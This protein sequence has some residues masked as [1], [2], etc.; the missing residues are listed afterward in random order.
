MFGI[1]PSRISVIF[2]NRK[3][4]INLFISKSKQ[5]NYILP[6]ALNDLLDPFQDLGIPANITLDDD[7][8]RCHERVSDAHRFA[9]PSSDPVWT[10]A[11]AIA[12]I[13]GIL[14]FFC[15]IVDVYLTQKESQRE[16]YDSRFGCKFLT[17]N[18]LC[19]P[20]LSYIKTLKYWID[21]FITSWKQMIEIL[22]VYPLFFVETWFFGITIIFSKT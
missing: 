13:F 1:C 7:I 14:V 21:C 22:R 8:F 9:N 20:H 18:W 2:I 10:A 11:V 16:R 6:K 3:Y 19:I 17:S 15:T 5:V 4:Y 12:I